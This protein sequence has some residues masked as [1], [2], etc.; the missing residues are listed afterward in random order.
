MMITLFT[1]RSIPS[2]ALLA[3]TLT[4]HGAAPDSAATRTTDPPA[5]VARLSFVGGTVSFRPG[6]VTDWT[7]ATINYPLTTG[8]YL[9]AD[10]GSRA[11]FTVGA[12]AFRLGPSTAAELLNVDDHTT[13]IRLTQGSVEARVRSLG[14]D[15]VIE[16]DTPSGAVTVL[17]TGVYRVDV[18]PDGVRSTV[19]V[20]R[21]S[22]EV[23][24]RNLAVQVNPGKSAVFTGTDSVTYTLAS[25]IP[26]DAW[27][28]W[29]AE[30]DRRQDQVTAMRYVSSEMTGYEDLD[31]FGTWRMVSDY[32]WVWAPADLPDGWAPYRFGYWAWVDP[33]GWT[34]VD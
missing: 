25:A 23:S 20:R 10:S 27:E 28:D 34:W 18:T 7:T 19:T 5:R 4:A 33:W 24:A 2:L 31:Y 12:D 22:A 29:C 6:S 1:L 16:I 8:D 30:R 9:W 17:R 21:G 14:G 3:S 26:T 32:G 11:E 13:Q 15:E